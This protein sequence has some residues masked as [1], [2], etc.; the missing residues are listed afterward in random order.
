MRTYLGPQLLVA[1][2]VQSV[3]FVL[4]TMSACFGQAAVHLRSLSPLSHH[5]F[6]TPPS[7]AVSSLPVLTTPPLAVRKFQPP[8]MHGHAC[9]LGATIRMSE[10]LK[11]LNFFA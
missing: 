10:M 2:H 9:G 6:H 1:A 11:S 5:A 7:C 4:V 8:D 3:Y